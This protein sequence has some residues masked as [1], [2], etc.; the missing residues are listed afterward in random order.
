MSVPL[1]ALPSSPLGWIGLVAAVGVGLAWL[2]VSF[3]REGRPRN[4]AA[5]LA[6]T[7]LYVVLLCFFVNL[8]RGALAKGS[9]GGA[10]GFGLLVA[11][12][13]IGLVLSAAR[14]V[15]ALRGRSAHDVSATN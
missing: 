1:I 9:T 15:G 13:G 6:A 2:V 8:L 4:V 5:W 14:T 12:F 11:I 7:G 3:Q 10:V